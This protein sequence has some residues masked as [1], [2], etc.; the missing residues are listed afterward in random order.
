MTKMF[1]NLIDLFTKPQDEIKPTTDEVGI[2]ALSALFIRIARLDGNFDISEREKIKELVKNRFQLGEEK[3]EYILARAAKLE[4]QSND[5]V[6]F[7]K[8]IKESIAYEERFSLLKDCWLL[9]MADGTRTYEEDG[10]MRLFCSLLGLSDKDNAIARQF[11][12][13]GEKSN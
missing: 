13:K 6:Q 12:S 3:T 9:V 2:L 5:N 1:K 10:F 7:T 8:I 4:S 11:I